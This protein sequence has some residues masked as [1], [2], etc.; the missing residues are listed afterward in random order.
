M[1]GRWCKGEE[2]VTQDEIDAGYVHFHKESAASWDMGHGGST[3]SQVGYWLRHV[4]AQDGVEM[5]PGVV[6][7]AGEIYP[8]MP[9]T[10]GL[11]AC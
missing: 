8:L 5:M 11:P 4:A 10:A 2:G 7:M 3:G 9:S 1:K 6:S